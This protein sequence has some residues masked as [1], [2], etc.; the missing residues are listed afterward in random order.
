MKDKLKIFTDQHREDFEIHE[1]DL[2]SA[3][4]SI[5]RKLDKLDRKKAK[6]PW[7]VMLK[8]AAAILVF[9]IVSLGFYL[10]DQRMA[11][12]TNGIALHNVSSE[13]AD[14]EAFYSSQI[15]DKIKIIEVKSG[16][17]DPEI[18]MQLKMLDDDYLSLKKDLNDNA[19]S[20]E[21]INAMIEYYRLKLAMLETILSEI[22]KNDD[23]KEHEEAQTI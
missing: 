5:D 23:N 15:A 2:D 10:N 14:T 18:Q 9:M 20:E 16:S 6:N 8:V 3:W 1:F 11:I 21:V 4:K 7:M 19:D 12:N 22:Q 13:L 17:L